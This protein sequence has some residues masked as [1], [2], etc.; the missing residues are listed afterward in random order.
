M[1]LREFCEKTGKNN[2]KYVAEYSRGITSK[3]KT[4]AKFFSGKFAIENGEIISLDGDSYSMDHDYAEI[5]LEI[6]EQDAFT[7]NDEEIPIFKKSD[8]ILQVIG[9]YEFS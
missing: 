5:K 2:F 1:T 8:E 7:C 9:E 6:A 3:G 4:I